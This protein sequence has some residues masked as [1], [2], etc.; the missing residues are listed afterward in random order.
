MQ[1]LQKHHFRTL[2][3]NENSLQIG[4]FLPNKFM[5]QDNQSVESIW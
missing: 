2:D 4:Q 3:G 1:V 5:A